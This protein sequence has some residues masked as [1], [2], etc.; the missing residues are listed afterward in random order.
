MSRHG[1]LSKVTAQMRTGNWR[2]NFKYVNYPNVEAALRKI[3]TA[4]EGRHHY[5]RLGNRSYTDMKDKRPI[6]NDEKI[7]RIAVL[8]ETQMKDFRNE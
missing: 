4:E 7:F 6:S 1:R 5:D 3:L 8:M 2:D